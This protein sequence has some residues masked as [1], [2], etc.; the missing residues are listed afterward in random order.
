MVTNVSYKPG[1]M[2]CLCMAGFAFFY[3][4][5]AIIPCFFD[6][7]KDAHHYCGVCKAKVGVHK[8]C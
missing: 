3:G 7:L 8:P 5:G 2:T 4:I 6:D 1:P